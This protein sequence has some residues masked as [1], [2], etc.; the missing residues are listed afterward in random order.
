[1]QLCFDFPMMPPRFEIA[2]AWFSNV[3]ARWYIG[4]HCVDLSWPWLNPW[5]KGVWP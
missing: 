5:P 1:M 2:G 4:A 3:N